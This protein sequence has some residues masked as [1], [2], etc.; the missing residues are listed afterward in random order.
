[1]TNNYKQDQLDAKNDS[2][3]ILTDDVNVNLFLTHDGC[4]EREKQQK[5]STPIIDNEEECILGTIWSQIRHRGRTSE[6]L[7]GKKTR[8]TSKG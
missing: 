7:E 4:L 2:T 8:W 6:Y 5:R 3:G 1:M